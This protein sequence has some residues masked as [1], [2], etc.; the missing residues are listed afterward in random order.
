MQWHNVHTKSRE[1]GLVVLKAN[2]NT[3]TQYG[4]IISLLFCLKER[5]GFLFK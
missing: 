4:E 2:R 5:K 3:H 1:N